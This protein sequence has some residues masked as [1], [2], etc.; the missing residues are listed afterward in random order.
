M[1]MNNTERFPLK[2][3]GEINL[4]ATNK[5]VAGTQKVTSPFKIVQLKLSFLGQPPILMNFNNTI[6]D[7]DSVHHYFSLLIGKNG[8]GKSSLL[9]E[10]IDFFVDVR[11]P[12][13]RKYTKQVELFSVSY[14]LGDN[15]YRIEKDE[16]SYRYYINDD[17][18]DAN[19]MEYPLIV[20]STMGMF[21][22]FP[23]QN[24]NPN[25]RNSRYDVPYYK[26]VG[27]RASNNLFTTKTNM[28]L[29]ILSSL[30]D[31]SSKSQLY[32]IGEILEFIGYDSKIVL[33]Y[34]VKEDVNSILQGKTKNLKSEAIEYLQLIKSSG[35]RTLKILPKSDS[36][37]R[38]K[39]M[40]LY[41]ICRFRQEGFLTSFH[42]CFYK[43]GQ[44]IECN[45]LSSGEFNMLSIVFS[46]ALSA[47]KQHL[48]V[49]LDEP[50]ISQHPNWQID[51]IDNLD[52]TLTD[53]GCHFIIATHCHYLV[54]NLPLRRSNVL[55]I[56][57]K[58][59]SVS[60]GVIL[61]ETYGWSAEEVLLK[62]F[63]MASDR[64]VYLAEMVGKLMTKIG[65]NDIAY[66]E[67]KKHVEFLERVAKYL[68]NV[69]PMK[70]IIETIA[71]EFASQK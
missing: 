40:H 70:S 57:E 34:Q 5:S 24:Q 21:D 58:E 14:V 13:P 12:N 17:I 59:E 45:R 25:V 69:D 16:K 47:E 46:V 33:K 3:I 71:R 55:K 30:T 61:S 4:D 23:V 28:M 65:Q 41:D 53:Y 19:Q 10:I 8:V 54:S 27:P 36:L 29:Q 42:C 62:T 6:A 26:Y 48:L 49:L 22:K 39:D 56:D 32:K 35:M 9:R 52:K 43:N 67:A 18:V 68:S 64:S 38:V 51:I 20:A 7:D 2:V 37:R 60:V 63:D 44:E 50:E 11:K 1:I 31:I 66:D 15:N